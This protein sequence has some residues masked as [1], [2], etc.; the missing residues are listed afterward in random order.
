[1]T[2]P[3]AIALAHRMFDL[4]REGSDELLTYLDSGVPVGLTDA[5]GSTLVMLAAYHDHASLVVGLATRGADMNA[6]NDRGQTP[7][8]GRLRRTGDR[9]SALAG[10]QCR[11]KSAIPATAELYSTVSM[12]RTADGVYPSCARIVLVRCA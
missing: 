7:L 9:D 4:A 12:R 6:L 1:V 8:A 10:R 11:H 3:D 5:A 2:D